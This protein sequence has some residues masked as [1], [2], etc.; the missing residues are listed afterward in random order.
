MF[1]KNVFKKNKHTVSLPFI[2]VLSKKK[3]YVNLKLFLFKL[4]L[5]ID[6]KFQINFR[7][8]EG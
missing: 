7:Y 8:I 6:F 5:Q 1:I 3:N 2:N 4:T